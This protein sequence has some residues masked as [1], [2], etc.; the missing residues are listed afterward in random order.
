MRDDEAIFRLQHVRQV[1]V[2]GVWAAIWAELH[3]AF[4]ER[5][6]HLASPSAAILDSQSAA[7]K[8]R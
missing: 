4:R 2:E 1:P 6:G 3:K 8:G 7:E 5:L